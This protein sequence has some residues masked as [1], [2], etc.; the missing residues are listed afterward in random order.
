L[1]YTS[2]AIEGNTL[3]HA[4]TALVVQEGVTVG[5]KSLVEHQEAI[6][7]AQAITFIKELASK[8]KRADLALDN[9]LAIHKHILQKIDD[10]H[11]GVLRTVAVRVMGLQVPRPNY[12]KVPQLMNEFMQW[13]QTSSDH[14][15]RVA[16]QAHLRFVFIHPFIDGNGR[17]ARLIFNLVLLQEGFPLVVIEKEQ[18]LAYINAIEKALHNQPE[19]YYMLMFQAIE[20]SLDVYLHEIEQSDLR[21]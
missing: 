19:D 18:R 7:H 20:H 14:V 21:G 13:L 2:N 10:E 15:A 4:E 11:A 12:L 6:N 5:G 8:K 9:I 16:A 1:T 3:S 17:T